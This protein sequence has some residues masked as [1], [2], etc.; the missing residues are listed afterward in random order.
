[1]RVMHVITSMRTGGAERLVSQML[2]LM[3]H[4]GLK[5][6]LALFD[7]TPTPLL[8]GVKE[9][10][11]T[12]YALGHGLRSVYDPRHIW[13]L[14]TLMEGADIVHT[15]NTTPQFFAVAARR[16]CGPRLVTTEHNTTNRR[17]GVAGMG[18]IDRAMYARYDAIVCCSEPVRLALTPLVAPHPRLLTIANGIDLAPYLA[19]PERDPGDDGMITIAMAGAFRPQKDHLTALRALALLPERFRLILAGDGP[20]R[21]AME[22]EARALGVGERVE[23]AGVVTDMPALYARADVALLAT[24]H[25][26]LSLTTIEAMASG[27]PLVASDVEGVRGNTGGGALLVTESDPEALASALTDAATNPSTRARLRRQGRAKVAEYDINR[28]VTNYIDLYMTL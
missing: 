19:L 26:G 18:A 11:I 10:G 27:V 25:E 2:P 24:H 9:A 12:V 22:R 16:G 23:F 13:R 7:A 15:H 8:R 4:R 17:R 1:M 3:Q 14:R 21:P 6:S 20:T 5:C 28:T